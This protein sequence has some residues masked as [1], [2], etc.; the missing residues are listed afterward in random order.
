[1]SSDDAS[2]YQVHAYN[3]LTFSLNFQHQNRKA[4]NI[5]EIPYI[6]SEIKTTNKQTNIQTIELLQDLH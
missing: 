1:M 2:Q 4:R 5:W 3:F 6:A